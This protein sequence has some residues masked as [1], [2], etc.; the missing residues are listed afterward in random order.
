MS[1]ISPSL[2]RSNSSLRA[3]QCRHIRP[4]A[5]LEVL[6]LR[7]FAEIEHPAGAGPVDARPASP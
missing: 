1:P 4:T 5:D 2:M 3:T 6:L 7:L